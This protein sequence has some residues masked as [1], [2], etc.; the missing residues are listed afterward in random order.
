VNTLTDE[1]AELFRRLRPTIRPIVDAVNAIVSA[2]V[3]GC[4]HM[5]ES[6]PDCPVCSLYQAAKDCETALFGLPEIV[7]A[8]LLRGPDPRARWRKNA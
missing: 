4:P 2:T 8:A 7:D 5:D 6:A 1:Q 3:S